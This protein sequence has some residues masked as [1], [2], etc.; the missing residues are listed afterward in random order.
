MILALRQRHRRIFIVLVLVLPVAFVAGLAAR[1]STPAVA[2]LP[3]ALAN[4][5]QQFDAIEWER[6]GLFSKS[7]VTVKLLRERKDSGAF[8]IEFAAPADF[9]KPDLLV[10]WVAGNPKFSDKL[11]DD[12]LL[13]GAFTPGVALPMPAGALSNGGVLVLYSLV[14]QGI[15][16]TSK[17]VLLSMP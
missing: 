5:P 14:E 9:L 13:L 4:T 3:V 11:P 1:K 8:A 12:A 2:A 6:A 16:E 17:A 7:P 10:Y 15:V